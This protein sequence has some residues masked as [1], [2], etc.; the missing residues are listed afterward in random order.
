MFSSEIKPWAL[1]KTRTFYIHFGIILEYTKPPAQLEKYSFWFLCKN[2]T[3]HLMKI[4]VREDRISLRTMCVIGLCVRRHPGKY[5][6]F[7]NG[8]QT[9]LKYLR[10]NRAK[11]Q[12]GLEL[13]GQLSN[14]SHYSSARRM[15][16]I[17]SCVL[18]PNIFSVHCLLLYEI[19]RNS[20][21]GN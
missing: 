17:S 5:I 13:I 9:R 2:N 19:L 21:V 14:H 7:C 11:E 12:V 15:M 4:S 16:S 20:G 18:A 1:K 6:S 10:L 3:L 8:A